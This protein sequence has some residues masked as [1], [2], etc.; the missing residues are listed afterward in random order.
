M[1]AMFQKAKA[2]NQDIGSWDVSNVEYLGFMF[3]QATAFNKN[4]NSW[5]VSKVTTMK[6]MFNDATSF[7]QNIGSWNIGE[8]TNFTNM[9][10]GAKLSTKN[11][12]ALLI[13]WS[14]LDVNEIKIPKNIIFEAGNSTYCKGEPSKNNLINTYN[15]QITDK[16]TDCTLGN[17]KFNKDS[18]LLYPNPV[19]TSFIINGL[20][21]GYNEIQ[22]IN[23][24]GGF[25]KQY[26]NYKSQ[27][28]N[29]ED[30]PNGI[31]F[32]KIHTSDNSIKTFK[33]IK[34]K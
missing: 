28:L 32:V 20:D 30:L 14:T 3:N 6:S 33:I 26:K 11:Y 31:Y 5:D 9:F 1:T 27:L 12:D 29:L 24:I 25:V 10:V 19:T 7:D 8:V 2:F 16:G 15:W 4:I 34:S 23:N 13:G 22:V 21:D 17:I 18:I